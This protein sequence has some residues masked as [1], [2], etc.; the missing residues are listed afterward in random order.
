MSTITEENLQTAIQEAEVFRKETLEKMHEKQRKVIEEFV[1][2]TDVI[3]DDYDEVGSCNLYCKIAL[4]RANELT[5]LLAEVDDQIVMQ[6]KKKNAI[7]LIYATNLLLVTIY[8][9]YIPKHIEFN[10]FFLIDNNEKKIFPSIIKLIICSHDLYNPKF[11]PE[12]EEIFKTKFLV[13][14]E[15]FSKE[16]KKELNVDGGKHKKERNE[17]IGVLKQTICKESFN[18]VVGAHAIDE[19]T[20]EKIQ[21]VTERNF[22]EY[23]NDLKF[24][25]SRYVEK[26]E[27]KEV[28]MYMPQDYRIRKS[29]F[30]FNEKPMLDVHNCTS[31]ELIP[32]IEKNGIK[33]G[34]SFVN[35][36]FLLFELW[37][38]KI[39]RIMNNINETFYVSKSKNLIDLIYQSFSTLGKKENPYFVTDYVG[40]Y[41]DEN[42]ALKKIKLQENIPPYHPTKYKEKNGKYRVIELHNTKN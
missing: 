20:D 2:N 40:I 1:K 36:R 3:K 24:F 5:N 19:D 22:D 34:I 11:A 27:F 4:I 35:F 42:D 21:I 25:L 26:V 38:L 41:H 29:I 28:Q 37:N 16:Y 8:Q 33:C 14:F 18:V 31:F 6:T 23:C 9:I 17:I 13:A 12:W 10:S 39:L 30:Y 32:Y 7:F 15:K